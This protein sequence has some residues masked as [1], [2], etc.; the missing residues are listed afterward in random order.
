MRSK[1]F[2]VREIDDVDRRI[3]QVLQRE[4]RVPMTELAERVGLSVTPCAERVKRLE[5]EGLIEGYFAR[6]NARRLGFNLLVYVELRL[7][8]RSG[9]DFERF[10]SAVARFPE[11]QACHLVCGDF[12]CLLKLR[13]PELAAYRPAL[14]DL[15]REL[16]AAVVSRSYVVTEELKDSFELALLGADA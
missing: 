7:A 4:A 6:L 9:P 15:Q 2:S 1:T 10:L 8:A 11:V 5:Q 3:L 16:P 14:A 12:D 13:I